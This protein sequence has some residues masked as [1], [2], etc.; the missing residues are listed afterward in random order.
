[1]LGIRSRRFC[2]RRSAVILDRLLD[3]GCGFL[4]VFKVHGRMELDMGIEGQKPRLRCRALRRFVR[5]TKL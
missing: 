2:V 4:Q 1:M 5:I 3:A